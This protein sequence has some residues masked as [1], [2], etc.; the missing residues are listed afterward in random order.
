MTLRDILI[1]TE[2]RV[3]TDREDRFEE[4]KKNILYSGIVVGSVKISKATML[5]GNPSLGCNMSQIDAMNNFP[6]EGFLCIVE[7]DIEFHPK[8]SHHILDVELD[9]DITSEWDCLYLGI[10]S[11]GFMKTK[12]ELDS[13]IHEKSEI[14]P[15]IFVRVRNM[16]ST[17][18]IL[19]LNPE[20]SKKIRNAVISKSYPV[21]IEPN[22]ISNAM[23]QKLSNCFALK[24]PMFYQEGPHVYCTKVSF[25]G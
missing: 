25:D 17:H 24:T 9:S 15:D 14:N 4:I 20:Y 11:W 6:K 19:H 8:F 22:D 13:V 7:D 21:Y 10:S 16:F 5:P 2:F 23:S 18:A 12:A 3:I 1:K